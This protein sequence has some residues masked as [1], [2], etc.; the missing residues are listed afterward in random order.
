MSLYITK[1]NQDILWNAINRNL[2]IKQFLDKLSAPERN[3]WFRDIIRML[4]EAKS[5]ATDLNV[6]FEVG[7]NSSVSL[8][9]V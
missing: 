4:L 7:A 8:L 3:T 1:E 6:S 5:R 9:S 2:Y